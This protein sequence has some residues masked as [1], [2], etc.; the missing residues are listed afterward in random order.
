M[1]LLRLTLHL[2]D[3]LAWPALALGYPLCA[4]IRAIETG[5]KYHMRKLVTYWTIFSFISLFEHLFEKLIQWIPLWPHIK[6]ITICWL[7]I[8]QFNGACYLYQILIHPYFLVKWHD[9]ISQFN[10]SCYVYLRLLCLCLSVNLQ[11]VTDWFNKP[12]EDPSLKN[13][14][15]LAVAERH[16]AE[17]GSDALEKLIA[18]KSKDFR[19]NHH[20][21]EIKPTDTSD[22]AGRLTL[23]QTECVVSGPVWED[24]TVMEHMAKHEAAESKQVKRVKENP[25]QIE[26][27]TAGVQV[28]EMVVSA[29]AEEIKLPEITFSKKVQTEWTCAVCQM[30]TTSEQNLKSHLNGS[31]HKAKCEGLKACKQTPKSEGS[32]PVTKSNQHNQQVKH[33]AVARSEHSANE[34]AEPKQLKSVKENLIQIGKKPTAMQIKGTALPVDAEEIKLPE[35]N[36]VKNVQ[37]EWTCVVCQVI[38]TS[39]HDLK[40]HLLGR[41]HR[42]R[43]EELKTCKQM[44]RTERNPPFASNMPD[45]LKQEQVKHALAAQKKNTRKKPKEKVQLGATTGQHQSQMQV[46]NAGGATHNSKLWCSFCDVWCPDKIAMAAHLNGRKHLAKLQEESVLLVEHGF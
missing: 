37:T 12:M 25:I 20:T 45:K 9:S 22:E 18:N 41:R 8:P 26:R 21:E 43:C 5:S 44:A 34:A 7:A 13:E 19:S 3:F 32:S 15:F 1:G 30:K 27:K 33:A 31:K 39:E 42:E 4:S 23:N 38:T 10:S 14:T 17:N 35:T 11:T 2:M 28:M 46:K 6:L 24:I 16:L 29:D 40:C 36:S